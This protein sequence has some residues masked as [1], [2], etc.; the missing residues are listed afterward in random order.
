MMIMRLEDAN[1]GFTT[2]RLTDG[3]PRTSVW[4]A[5][6]ANMFGITLLA[7]GR[8]Q[9]RGALCHLTDLQQLLPSQSFDVG[10]PLLL[11]PFPF[12]AP[13]LESDGHRQ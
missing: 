10:S 11:R 7:P 9:I 12:S 2:N 13:D 5:V 6:E 4:C 3:Q 1:C 8:K